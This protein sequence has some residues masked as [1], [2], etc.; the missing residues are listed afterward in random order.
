MGL[1]DLRNNKRYKI[2][3]FVV[4]LLFM[5]SIAQNV[6]LWLKYNRLQEIYIESIT[7]SKKTN[8]K[9]EL[10]SK[11]LK[12]PQ[13]EQAEQAERSINKEFQNLNSEVLKDLENKAHH[14][15]KIKLLENGD[16]E[17]SR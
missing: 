12:T 7:T 8:I 4:I 13:A 17:A 3:R 1:Q 14:L 9:T 16:T 11:V 5:V 15:K 10:E 6:A 2:I